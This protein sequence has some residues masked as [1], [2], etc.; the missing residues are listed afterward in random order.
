MLLALA[1]SPSASACSFAVGD[2]FAVLDDGTD[3]IAPDAPAAPGVDIHRGVGPSCFMGRCSMTSCD[4]LGWIELTFPAPA[5]DTYG[6]SDIGYTLEVLAGSP[7]DGLT[8]DETREP[9]LVTDDG[10][11]VLTLVWA[12]GSTDV[13]EAFDFDLGLTAVDRG[14]NA[15]T[16]TVV[17]LADPGRAG[18]CSYTPVSGGLLGVLLAMAGLR[19]R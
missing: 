1:L 19:R 12:D 9:D 16:T 14:G 7:P 3:T 13:Q 18:G 4:D 17:N 2:A 10:D 5:D 15:S 6:P 8:I 11:V